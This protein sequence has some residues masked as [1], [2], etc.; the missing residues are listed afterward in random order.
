GVAA[1]EATPASKLSVL[2]GFKVELLY[3]PDKPTE[4]SWV[5]MAID[6]K[7]RLIVSP[8]DKQPLLRLTIADGKIEKMEKIDLPVTSSMGMLYAFDSLYVSGRGPNGIGLYRLR[9]TDNDDQYDHFD[10][11]LPGESGEHGAHAPVR[12]PEQ[13]RHCSNR[14]FV[15]APAHVSLSHPHIT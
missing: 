2:N 7:G 15:T 11:L 6:P 9:D 12:G 14:H 10:F 8:Q 5:A 3:S 1:P 4:G 13:M